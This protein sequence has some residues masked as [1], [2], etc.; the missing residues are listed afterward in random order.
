MIGGC[1]SGAYFYGVT[2]RRE[3]VL[4][5]CD[6]SHGAMNCNVSFPAVHHFYLHFRCIEVGGTEKE[7]TLKSK[8][9]PRNRSQ[10]SIISFLCISLKSGKL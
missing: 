6:T 3:C 4:K 9:F 2:S 10:Q 8:F 5:F 1:I 7:L